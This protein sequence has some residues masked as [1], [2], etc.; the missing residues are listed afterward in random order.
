MCSVPQCIAVCTCHVELDLQG[1]LAGDAGVSQQL[2]GFLQ[3]AILGGD[4]VDG[5]DAVADLQ[6][7]TPAPQTEHGNRA[8]TQILKKP[9]LVVPSFKVDTLQKPPTKCQSQLSRWLVVMAQCHWVHRCCLN[10]KGQQAQAPN[11]YT[12]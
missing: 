2:V 10:L 12:P 1:D 11:Y 4:A 5:Q 6:D 3:G 8:K 9:K 7:S